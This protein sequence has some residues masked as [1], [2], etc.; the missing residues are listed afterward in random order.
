MFALQCKILQ[1]F[2]VKKQTNKQT[3]QV[4]KKNPITNKQ[5]PTTKTTATIVFLSTVNLVHSPTK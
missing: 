3:K 5:K 2:T 1:Y 4:T